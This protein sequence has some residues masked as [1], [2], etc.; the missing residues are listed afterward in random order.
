MLYRIL[1]NIVLLP[2]FILL[3]CTET[4]YTPQASGTSNPEPVHNLAPYAQTT[5][6]GRRMALVIGNQSYPG[7]NFPRLPN[8]KQNAIGMAERLQQYGFQVTRGIDLNPLQM[9]NAVN[10]FADSL[11]PNDIALFYYGGHGTVATCKNGEQE[12]FLIP[13][14]KVLRSRADVCYHATSAQWVLMRLNEKRRNG[15]NI[16]LLDA[17]RTT[18][19]QGSETPGLIGMQ[20]L[21]SFIG[22]ASSPGTISRG[23][24]W[25][26]Y[27]VFTQQVLNML[28]PPNDQLPLE[29][30]FRKVRTATLESVRKEGEQQ[31]PWSENGLLGSEHFCFKQPCQIGAVVSSPV[32]P[33]TISLTVRSNVSSSKAQV[34][35]DGEQRG[36]PRLTVKLVPGIHQV[37]V[38]AAG[39]KPWEKQLEINRTYAI[40]ANLEQLPPSRLPFEPEMVSIPAGSFRMGDIQ[41]GGASDEKPVH[42]VYIKSFKMGKYEITVGQYMACVRDGGCKPPEWQEKGS[43]YNAKTGSDDHYRKL[44][45]ALT[46]SNHPIVGVSWHDA[47]AYTKWLSR[48]TGKKYR[49]PTEAEWEYVARAGTST[50]YWWGNEI[51]HNRA[52]CD[53]CGSKWDDKSTSPVGS[54]AAN[55]WGIYDTVGNVWEWTC[56]KYTSPYDGS[57]MKCLLSGASARVFRGGSWSHYADDVRAAYRN[58]FEPGNQFNDVGFRACEVQVSQVR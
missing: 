19:T 15:M 30:W 44:G 25:G 48:K 3:G 31:I 11:K 47:L 41:G 38:V 10:S 35:I 50:K 27:S 32:V 57:E 45:S 6:S 43:E 24:L 21:G 54:F 7:G 28:T 12:N 29:F 1:K 22:Y 20:Q 49:L 9:Q 34:F 58:G 39:Y 26:K 51:G 46:N 2:F 52:N 37:R 16:V 14:G 40:Y 23:D 5:T 8:P 42:E 33:K 36:S 53:G 17:C 18:T 4:S 56:S 13:V 55:P